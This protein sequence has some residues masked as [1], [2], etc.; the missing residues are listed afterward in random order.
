M[1]SRVR[2]RASTRCSPAEYVAGWKVLERK[3]KKFK[4]SV[5]ALVGV[6]VWRAI[7]PLLDVDEE[8]R[9]V[10]KKS[11]CPGPQPVTVHGAR[12][13]VL[14]NPSGRNANFSYAEMLEAFRQLKTTPI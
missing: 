8:T 7:V 10:L 11:K 2:R 6:T 13:H 3:I 12:L 4:P 1:S 14:P 5:V 9:A